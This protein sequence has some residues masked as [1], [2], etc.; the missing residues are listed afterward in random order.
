MSQTSK[1]SVCIPTYNRAQYL[2]E[3][4]ESV[5]MQSFSDFELIICDN[6]SVDDTREV[7]NSFCD[8]R[9]SYYRNPENL[10]AFKNINLCLKLAKGEYIT[11]FHDDDV[12][13]QDNL[14]V[15]VNFLEMHPN[16]GMVG[17][18][19][20]IIDGYGKTTGLCWEEFIER[21]LIDEGKGYFK[22]I[23]LGNNV[24]CF[25]AVLCRR[26]C[27]QELGE[28]EEIPYCDWEMWMRISLFYDLAYVQKP[29]IKYRIHDGNDHL[30]YI[31]FKEE[32]KAKMFIVNKYA[33]K[34]PEVESLECDMQT[35]I[36]RRIVGYSFSNLSCN[37]KSMNMFFLLIAFSISINS[38]SSITYIFSQ[39]LG[40]IRGKIRFKQR[41]KFFLDK[42]TKNHA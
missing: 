37:H 32:Y 2:R 5:L 38:I 24:F 41:I 11:I 14:L 23:F 8:D 4:I 18:N 19:T 36:C 42:V 33:S 20:Y 6:A 29:L 9:I 12:M 31:G 3:S 35:N 34:I 39:L 21:N 25:P 28:F 30:N 16:I 26:K 13:L 15:K 40:F 7:V 27:Y 22:K 1:V 17:S 10:G